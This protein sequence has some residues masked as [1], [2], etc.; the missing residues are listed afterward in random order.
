MAISQMLLAGETESTGELTFSI[1]PCCCTK[2][3]M[4]FWFFW[5]CLGEMPLLLSCSS[6]ACQLGS[7]PDDEKP[8]SESK[9][10]CATCLNEPSDC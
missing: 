5:I 2:S 9:P 4:N 10:M 7:T 6:S 8:F 1:P 3:S